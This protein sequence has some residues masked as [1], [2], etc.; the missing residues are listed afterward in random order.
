MSWIIETHTRTKRE[1]TARPLYTVESRLPNPHTLCTPPS[2]LILK[3]M[4]ISNVRCS[5][6]YV[7]RTNS[8]PDGVKII[9]LF[10]PVVR[11][12]MFIFSFSS[13]AGHY[14]SRTLRAGRLEIESKRERRNLRLLYGHHVLGQVIN[15]P[16][17][18][19]SFET[20]TTPP[21]LHESFNR[22]PHTT[23]DKQRNIARRIGQTILQITNILSCHNIYNGPQANHPT[24]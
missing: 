6:V 23:M 24:V 14:L 3:G 11:L 8:S 16:V 13:P 1:T 4:Y 21:A 9:F 10:F 7:C 15:W 19:E 12:S 18:A 5:C 22:P 20:H 17:H 2:A